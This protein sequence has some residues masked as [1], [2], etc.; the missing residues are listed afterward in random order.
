VVTA[1]DPIDY[2]GELAAVTAAETVPKIIT[3]LLASRHRPKLRSKSLS[4][5]K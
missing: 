5:G 1:L 3:I 2:G 4:I